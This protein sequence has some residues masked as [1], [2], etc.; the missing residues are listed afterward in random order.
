M[1]R[2]TWNPSPELISRIAKLRRRLDSGNWKT[3]AALAKEMGITRP[4]LHQLI[5]WDLVNR[6]I[7]PPGTKLKKQVKW[8]IKEEAPHE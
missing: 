6:K 1:G 5:K 2:V 7:I 4:Y 8:D 3:K